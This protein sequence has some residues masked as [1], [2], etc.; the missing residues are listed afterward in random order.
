M[1][2]IQSIPMNWSLF[3]TSIV[4]NKMNILVT[5][6]EINSFV[7][8]RQLSLN[9]LQF[10]IFHYYLTGEKIQKTNLNDT[11]IT[12]TNFLEYLRNIEPDEAPN[13]FDNKTPLEKKYIII[14]EENIHSCFN[15]YIVKN[16]KQNLTE[17]KPPKIPV[18]FNKNIPEFIAL[19]FGEDNFNLKDKKEHIILLL[20]NFYLKYYNFIR[21]TPIS[22]VF[23]F[24]S[25][26]FDEKSNTI[27]SEQFV[28]LDGVSSN[29]YSGLMIF[30]FIKTALA[31]RSFEGSIR[32][33]LRYELDE[34]NQKYLSETLF[35][36][37]L[38]QLQDTISALKNQNQHFNSQ[39]ELSSPPNQHEEEKGDKNT[40]PVKAH[41][42]REITIKQKKLDNEEPA[43]DMNN[44]ALQIQNSNESNPTEEYHFNDISSMTY[45]KT[46]VPRKPKLAKK[47]SY[48]DEA[49]LTSPGKFDTE[50]SQ[51]S[52]YYYE[53]RNS[54]TGMVPFPTF[55]NG[56]KNEP[57]LY[58]KKIVY[59][60]SKVF[61]GKSSKGVNQYRIN[62][63]NKEINF[64][65]NNVMNNREYFTQRVE[66]INVPIILEPSECSPMQ[67]YSRPRLSRSKNRKMKAEQINQKIFE[68]IDKQ[69][70]MEEIQMNKKKSELDENCQ[71]CNEC[72]II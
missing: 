9:L 22:K 31:S 59:G 38:S 1:N 37:L 53:A 54:T 40:T 51:G 12:T 10:L 26:P 67:G 66:Q 68:K 15:L 11:L 16:I 43:F 69:N 50:R 27:I 60:Q 62:R 46:C 56:N 2:D 24:E 30:D 52:I 65:E 63:D 33:S 29:F 36:E 3:F 47:L 58:K 72:K 44:T 5:Q 8:K 35:I 61:K 14:I 57:D 4:N 25:P 41:N 13:F 7:E 20:E 23:K 48:Y 39:S 70:E 42:I 21:S 71:N 19:I 45:R 32:I 18:S 64:N 28:S 6:E 17:L 55:R 49:I 34:G